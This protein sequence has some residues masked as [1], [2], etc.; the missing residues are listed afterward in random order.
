M[1]E[2]E[3]MPEYPWVVT[4]REGVRNVHAAYIQEGAG[5][6]IVTGHATSVVLK[7]GQHKTVF[8][9]PPGEVIC[10]ERIPLARDEMARDFEERGERSA[11][12]RKPQP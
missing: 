9:A 12:A 6:T 10:I 2:K 3:P 1:T 8:Y 5:S 11:P 7:D 4:L